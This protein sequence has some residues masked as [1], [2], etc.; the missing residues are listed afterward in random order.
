MEA[1]LLA[2]EVS[3]QTHDSIAAEIEGA[4]KNGQQKQDS[5][6]RAEAAGA[7]DVSVIAGLLLGSPEFQ[8]R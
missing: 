2:G 7:A 8:R 5:G 3:K 4:A 1:S 6:K